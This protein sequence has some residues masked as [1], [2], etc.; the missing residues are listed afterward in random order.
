MLVVLGLAFVLQNAGHAAV[1]DNGYIRLSVDRTTGLYEL[2]F[3]EGPRIRSID[4]VARLKGGLELRAGAYLIHV[5]SPDGGELVKDSLGVGT[6]LTVLHRAPGLPELRQTFWI[7]RGRKEA[8]V[9]LEVKSPSAIESNY[10]API[11]SS[12]PVRLRHNKE[13]K[14][15]FVPYDNDSYA[16]Y[17]TD[18][19]VHSK[20]DLGSNELG[21]VFDN[22]SRN[23]IVV[24]SIEHALWK[25]GV[26]FA[27]SRSGDVAGIEAFVGSRGPA[28]QQQVPHGV[29]SGK[30]IRTPKF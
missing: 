14:S 6:R 29:V 19:W 26:R 9:Q 12:Q 30:L 8:I 3:A 20:E 21:A 2:D 18:C 15:L 1:V 16:R 28:S 23:G 24:G 17:R 10:L 5:I 4:S 22:T 27:R 11:K 7:Y 25:S 13:I